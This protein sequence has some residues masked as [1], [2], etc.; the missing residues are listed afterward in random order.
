MHALKTFLHHPSVKYVPSKD[1][2]IKAED[3]IKF[4]IKLLE[5]NRNFSEDNKTHPLDINCKITTNVK[6][7][8]S[9]SRHMSYQFYRIK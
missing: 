4:A 3:L 9:L 8:T 7:Q 5:R 6:E 1:F 2:E